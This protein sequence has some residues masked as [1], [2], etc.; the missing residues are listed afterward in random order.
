[1][2]RKRTGYFPTLDGW[3]AL[4]ALVVLF[5][6][7]PLMPLGTGWF[8][9]HQTFGVEIFFGISGLLICSRLLQEEEAHGRINLKE[10]Y[11]RRGFRILPPLMGYLLVVG[12]LG[13][14]HVVQVSSREW[15]ASLLFYRNY[16]F[17]AGTSAARFSW[18]TGHFWSLAVEEHFYLILPGLLVF[19][20]KKWRVPAL[21][22]LAVAVAGWRMYLQ[23]TRGSQ[24]DW[25]HHTDS[26]LD[27]LLIP[28]VLA[29]VLSSARGRS[30]LTPIVRYWLL[31]AATV[32]W[33]VSNG[34]FELLT[35]IVESAFIPLVLLGT[36]L[37]PVG[38]LAKFLELSPMRWLGRISYSIYLWQQL[39]FTGYFHPSLHPF[40]F[41]TNFPWRWIALLTCAT[42]S[43]YCLEKPLIRLGHRIAPPATPGRP[44]DDATKRFQT[45]VPGDLRSEPA[46]PPRI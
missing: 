5:A 42:A 46:S 39:F 37:H 11:I 26:I 25:A 34:G 31:L 20:R 30:I 19:V 15:I 45:V 18:Y 28:A 33:L 4:A 2:S 24:V 41:L 21:L 14:L 43:Y 40:G 44:D 35:P 27:A 12:L 23:L 7:D 3:R 32:L 16:G 36:V 29:I 38:L 10:F 6:H 8:H 13:S 17:L 22:L 1:M 9:Q